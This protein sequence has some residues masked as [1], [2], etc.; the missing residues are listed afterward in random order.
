MGGGGGV[1]I[2]QIMWDSD[3]IVMFSQAEVVWNSDILYLCFLRPKLIVD[4][5][6]KTKRSA[7]KRRL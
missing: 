6:R 3:I 7:Q 1:E 4:S 2:V 5:R